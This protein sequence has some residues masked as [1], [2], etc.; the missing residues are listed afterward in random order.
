[1]LGLRVHGQSSL[2]RVPEDR[3]HDVASAARPA[4]GRDR[5][6]KR[7]SR[8]ARRPSAT[9]T[10]TPRPTG[11]KSSPTTRDRAL[12]QRRP[13]LA[14]RRADD[15]S[16]RGRQAR[17]LRE[18]ARPRRGRELEIWRRVAATGVKHICAFNYRFV[19]AVRLAREMIDAGELGEI[20]HF[21]GRYLQDWGDDPTLDT[22][23]F[24][25]DEAGRAHSATSGA[26]RRPSAFPRRR[27]RVRVGFVK[28]FL[29][30]R[31]STTRS[32]P[33]SSSRT[34]QSARSRRPGSRSAAGTR[35][36]GRST[37]RRDR[38]RST[39]NG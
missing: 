36:S 1:M 23:R 34:A 29:P 27:D 33:R 39:W 21:R 17:R 5:G 8:A 6:A 18:A 25:A 20:R 7:G 24:H 31:R 11:A 32:R 22:W 13:E 35:S 38:S 4:A 19:P 26:R 14:P 37:A 12:R 10:S 3:L 2:E 16:S 9:A 30:G 15:R 28:T